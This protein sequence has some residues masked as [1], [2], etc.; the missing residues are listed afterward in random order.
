VPVAEL[1]AAVHGVF[2]R[3]GLA[4]AFRHHVGHGLGLTVDPPLI[5]LGSEDS[6]EEGDFVALEP[7]LYLPGVGGVRFEN[8]YRVGRDGPE[9]LTTF[10][11]ATTVT[12]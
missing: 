3:A 6:L 8:D 9:L 11:T 12:G 1:C 7:G 4:H 2:D 5:R 10:P